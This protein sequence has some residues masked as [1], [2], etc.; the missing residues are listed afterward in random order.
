M[1]AL[2]LGQQFETVS[3]LLPMLLAIHSSCMFL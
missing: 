2:V 1:T 3:V